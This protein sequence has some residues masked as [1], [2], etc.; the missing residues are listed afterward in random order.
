MPIIDQIDKFILR[1]RVKKE[2]NRERWHQKKFGGRGP[3][4]PGSSPG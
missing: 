2:K 3:L 4:P 1:K